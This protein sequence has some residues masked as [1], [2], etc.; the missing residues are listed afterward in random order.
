MAQGLRSEV[1][2]KDAVHC[3]GPSEHSYQPLMNFGTLQARSPIPSVRPVL[4]FSIQGIRIE[5]RHLIRGVFV[6]DRFQ[7]NW[8]L[9]RRVF[10]FDRFYLNVRD[11]GP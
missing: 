5:Y 2:C 11:R 7:L 10:I 1:R 8:H 9:T 3:T 6:Y 4:P